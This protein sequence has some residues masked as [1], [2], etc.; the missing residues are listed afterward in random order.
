M[1]SDMSESGIQK[2]ILMNGMVDASVN[3][4]EGH[5]VVGAGV[6]KSD[7]GS[8]KSPLPN[9]AVVIIGWGVEEG[10]GT[11][12]WLVRNSYGKEFG[13]NGNMKIQRGKNLFQ[14]EQWVMGY[15]VESI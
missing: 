13:E 3:M 14:I 8:E 10:S 9:H 6:M 11:K 12:Y 5:S 15:D 2:E 1:L 7:I 4:P